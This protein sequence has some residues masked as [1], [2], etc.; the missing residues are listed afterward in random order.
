M[1]RLCA[2]ILAL[3]LIS[4]YASSSYSQFIVSSQ[5][6]CE[7]ISG[8]FGWQSAN[9]TVQAGDVL[10]ICATGTIQLNNQSP[11]LT[12]P[13]GE[14]DEGPAGAGWCAPSAYP[15]QLLGY[16]NGSIFALG[17][18]VTVVA[19]ASGTLQ[20][21]INDEF[22]D[23]NNGDF[24][25]LVDT[26]R[27]MVM[28]TIRGVSSGVPFSIG[29]AS[30]TA[31]APQPG[32]LTYM[33]I[34]ALPLG[35]PPRDIANAIIAAVRNLNLGGCGVRAGRLNGDPKNVVRLFGSINQFWVGGAGEELT[36]LPSLYGGN[37][38]SPLAPYAPA[39]G[40]CVFNPTMWAAD[41]WY[42]LEPRMSER[43]SDYRLE[44]PPPTALVLA[45]YTFAGCD[46]EGWNSNDHTEFSGGGVTAYG[47][48]AGLFS[49]AAVLDED[50]CNSAPSCAWGFFS[51]SGADYSCGNAPFQAAV[52]YV[53]ADDH[54]I[55]NSVVSPR[56]DL[57]G[58]TTRIQLEF[59]TYRDLDFDDLVF[60][61][62]KVRS[63]VGGEW[64]DWKDDEYIYYGGGA[65]WY[66]ESV[67]V[68][69]LLEAGA[70]SLQ[71][72][73]GVIDM[74]GPWADFGG[75]V[76]HSHA[77][78]FGNVTVTSLVETGPTWSV[79]EIDLFQDSFPHDGTTTGTV[80][81]D[82]AADVN[83][84]TWPVYQ[85]GDS[86]VV[87]VYDGTVGLGT[88][89]S[90]GA[91]VYAYVSVDP[92]Q[93]G[94]S[95]VD[96]TDDPVHYPVVDSVMAD[97]VMWYC[98]LMDSAFVDAGREHWIDH[99]FRVDLDDEL[100]TPGDVVSF[101]FAA[102]NGSGMWSYWTELVGQTSSLSEAAAHP[103][104]FSCLPGQGWMSGGDI[105]YVDVADGRGVQ[106]FFDTA[107]SSMGLS[108][109]RY[110]VRG[111]STLQGNGL[112]SRIT[113]VAA[114]LADCYSRIIWASGDLRRGAITD[115]TGSAKA[116]DAA[117]LLAFLDE[118]S[119][120]GGVYFSGDHLAEEW[121]G[122]AGTLALGGAYIP[123]TLVGADHGAVGLGLSPRVI[124]EP[125]SCFDHV[126]GPDSI[127]VAGG[128]PPQRRFDVLAAVGPSTQEMRYD[129]GGP[130]NNGAVI[131]NSTVN[132]N[133]AT[134]GVVLSGFS[135]DAI[136]DD[137]ADGSVARHEHLRDILDWLGDAPPDPTNAG[138]GAHSYALAQNVPNPFN[139]VTTIEYSLASPGRVTL[140]IYNV[141]GQL[142]RTLVGDEQRPA[143]FSNA[144]WDGRNDAGTAVAS[145]VYFYR[146]IAGSFVETRKMVLLK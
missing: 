26:G 140:R 118:L 32:D 124:G 64:G 71:V 43:Q 24:T 68:G 23:D 33:T 138:P 86:A 99:R 114:Q 7:G 66:R 113:D 131:A 37:F 73:L 94:K 60:Y 65:D 4:L 17:S 6:G 39:N 76:C 28:Y 145:G 18:D 22:Y 116:D 70:D 81:A 128:C 83:P 122:L 41:P 134:V 45:D 107:F 97:G 87:T 119:E 95:G 109:D 120:S 46:A 57:A 29:V 67:E 72:S 137:V 16:I 74:L 9:L 40:G 98:I 61:F 38:L 53:D 146:L 82:I 55:H 135:F 125:A 121:N 144:R 104:E 27:E 80:H 133:S 78:L 69:H 58:A 54:Y 13:D 47:D 44:P 117:L 93:P 31:E 2:P 123:H 3:G 85:P 142:I 63:R 111:A 42:R 101:F 112:S 84:L 12:T 52:P 105:L 75:G 51:G 25:V 90:G 20:L 143:G 30:R 136:R 102:K 96:L 19:P 139:P 115:G 92:P 108:V 127:F 103:C 89:M 59:D 79:R 10:N 36:C 110:D 91:A 8:S 11:N 62:Y 56:I 88:D 5:A 35:A 50:A 77:P 129:G 48:F 130:G 14:T 106:P 49:S 100:F 141:A 126:T 15:G 34:P 132:G 1:K 21:G